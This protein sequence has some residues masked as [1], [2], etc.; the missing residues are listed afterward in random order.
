MHAVAVHFQDLWDELTVEDALPLL[1]P[2]FADWHPPGKTLTT[3]LRTELLCLRHVNI[4]RPAIITVCIH[5]IDLP[6]G[7]RGYDSV[8][9]VLS[10]QFWIAL[11]R[12]AVATTSIVEMLKQVS[13][14]ERTTNVPPSLN[15]KSPW[16][17]RLGSGS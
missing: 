5:M 9:Q 11:D 10:N 1:L 2:P 17:S 12:I 8:F 15:S 16:T 3:L 14:F 4:V 7:P 13:V 6:S